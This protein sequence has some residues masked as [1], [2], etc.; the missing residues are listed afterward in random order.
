[1]LLQ[2]LNLVS[3]LPILMK[4]LALFVFTFCSATDINACECHFAERIRE[5]SPCKGRKKNKEK[6]VTSY[7]KQN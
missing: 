5:E 2:R 3:L 6:T 7:S 1:M 4:K